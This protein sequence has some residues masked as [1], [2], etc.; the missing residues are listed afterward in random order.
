MIKVL[1]SISDA[2]RLTSVA[3]EHIDEASDVPCV[4]RSPSQQEDGRRWE[5]SGVAGSKGHA[6]H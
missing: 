5:E 2:S 6:P 1:K 3:L 4:Q